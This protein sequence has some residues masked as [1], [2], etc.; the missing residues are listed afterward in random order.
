[1]NRDL[2]IGTSINQ[3][4]YDYLNIQLYNNDCAATHAYYN[5]NQFNLNKW[6]GVI[7]NG[8]SK[9]AK[10]LVGIPG[11]KAE[12]S[13]Y[14]P[15]A[16]LADVYNAAKGVGPLLSRMAATTLDRSTPFLRPDIFVS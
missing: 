1:M 8:A 12:A 11:N 9:N 6:P 15:T 10:L 13:E 16:H 14:I 5:T 2:N 4:K 3:A 7:A